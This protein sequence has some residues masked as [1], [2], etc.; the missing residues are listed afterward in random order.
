MGPMYISYFRSSVVFKFERCKE[1]SPRSSTQL[2]NKLQC[3]TSWQKFLIE[4][5]LR[6]G[7]NPRYR[8]SLRDYD[9]A[10]ILKYDIPTSLVLSLASKLCHYGPIN[11]LLSDSGHIFSI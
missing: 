9:D 7:S 3:T 2:S 5:I 6:E 4:S 11:L 1:D 10:N 8:P